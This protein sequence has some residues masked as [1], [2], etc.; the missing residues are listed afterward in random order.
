MQRTDTTRDRP[1]PQAHPTRPLALSLCLTALAGALL[2]VYADV[3][4]HAFIL[5][6]DGQYLTPE[7]RRGLTAGNIARALGS[8]HF[9]NWQPLTLLSHMTDAQLFGDWAGGHKWHSV[10]L[11]TL[12]SALLAALLLRLTGRA[13]PCAAAAALFALH[14]LRVESVAWVADRKDLLCAVL[15]LACLHAHVSYAR[16]PSPARMAGSL[17]LLTL[18]LMAKA[19]AI[20]LPAIMLLLDLWPLNRLKA[21]VDSERR[22]TSAAGLLM[23]KAPHLAISL[24]FAILGVIAARQG[25]SGAEA[26]PLSE[27]LAYLFIAPATYLRQTLWL[28]DYAPLVP[29]SRGPLLGAA[30]GSAA[31]LCVITAWA[32]WVARSR[33]WWAVGWAWF[34][35]ALLPVS[36]LV[37]FGYH[38][39]ADRF[40]YLPHMGLALALAAALPSPRPGPA[41]WAY[42]LALL[43][44]LVTLAWNAQGQVHRWRSSESIFLHTL[45]VTRDNHVIHN[46]LAMVYLDQKRFDEALT[47]LT[48]ALR[49]EPRA[50][51]YWHNLTTTLTRAGRE[52]QAADLLRLRARDDPAQ[53]NRAA[54][55]AFVNARQRGELHPELTRLLGELMLSRGQP[56]ASAAAYRALLQA[57]P[58]DADALRGLGEASLA[59]G[60]LADAVGALR[61]SVELDPTRPQA[62]EAL[63]LALSRAGDPDAAKTAQRRAAELRAPG[64]RSPAP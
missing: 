43:V 55:H 40:T 32:L 57:R 38:A 14:P 11:H 49:I 41:R 6:D 1:L 54:A 46:N 48:Q 37:D 10:A 59:Q 27:R 4:H 3:H 20:V 22:G 52:A 63:S 2:W 42:A 45:S 24:A 15:S 62:W 25:E 35:V 53:A 13:W 17:T 58:R 30:L 47:H 21:T 44:T 36:G 50:D 8:F 9:S 16:E 26:A 60:R 28:A 23:E 34:L 39:H 19:S 56:S 18:A 29:R 61:A 33:P 5:L 51:M 31:I 12:A 7:F 64:V